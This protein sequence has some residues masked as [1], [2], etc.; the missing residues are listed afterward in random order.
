[1]DACYPYAGHLLRLV[2]KD[3]LSIVDG[4]TESVEINE[5]QAEFLVER[6][7]EALHRSLKNIN[8]DNRQMHQEEEASHARKAEE[9]RRRPGA[10]MPRLGA[11]YRHGWDVDMATGELVLDRWW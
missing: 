10:T 1:V 5:R 6:A 8:V 4:D 7:A 9:L 11:N 2:G 3:Y